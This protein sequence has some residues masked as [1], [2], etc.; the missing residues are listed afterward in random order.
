MIAELL[1]PFGYD[2]MLNAMLVSALIG[3]GLRLFIR[4]LNAK[5][6]VVNR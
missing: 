1:S 4:I 2:Y 3:G 5:R 6:L